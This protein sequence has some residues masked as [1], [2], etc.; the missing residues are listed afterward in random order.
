MTNFQKFLGAFVLFSFVGCNHSERDWKRANATNTVSSYSEF[1]AKHPHDAHVG[2]ATMLID[3]LDW[4]VASTQ[5]TFDGYN[6][7][8]THHADGKYFANAK[9]GIEQLPLRLSIA[10]VEVASRFQAYVGG[11]AN[12]EPPTP[13]DF[14]G[15]GGMPL[16]SI[17]NGSSFLAGE[18]NSTDPRAQLIRIETEIRNPAKKP[19]FFKIGELS[20]AIAGTRTNE[21]IA[22]GYD[23]RLC[24]MSDADRQKVK[25][26]VVE[27][28]P[29][30]RR[31]LSYVFPL[32]TAESEQG[33]LLLERAA[34]VSF[35]IGKHLSK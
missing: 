7:Y 9:A 24:A 13:I 10:S 8:L 32:P 3:E 34:P 20:F 12:I 25:Q 16:I 1:I 4:S 35:E 27:V 23:N 14:G 30:S 6:L 31:S 22:V 15:G 2:Q 26:I 21:F 29:Q 33:Q 17:S 28:S 18:V 5:N 19:A 11:G